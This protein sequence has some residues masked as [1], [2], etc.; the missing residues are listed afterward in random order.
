MLSIAV[1][2]LLLA[3]VAAQNFTTPLDEYIALA[4]PTYSYFDTVWHWPI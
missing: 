2:A 3:C 1:G 4:D